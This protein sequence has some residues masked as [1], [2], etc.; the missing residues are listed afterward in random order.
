MESTPAETWWQ[1]AEDNFGAAGELCRGQR[2]RSSISR[3]YYAS[4]SA[5]V[6]TLLDQNVSMPAR[7][8]PSH[9]SLPTLVLDHVRSISHGRRGNLIGVLSVLY[10]LRIAADYQP[11]VQVTADDARIAGA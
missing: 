11:L 6:S 2:F 9:A 7:G 4:Y 10:R 5:L 8:N 1:M 3:A